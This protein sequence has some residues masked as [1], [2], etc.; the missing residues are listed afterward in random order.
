MK[1]ETLKK[2]PRCGNAFECFGEQDC[3]C[4]NF[5]VHRK[6]MLKIMENY[7]DCLCRDCLM[8]FAEK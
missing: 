8:K 5:E 3:W 6:E 4:E 1:K 2:C 7:T